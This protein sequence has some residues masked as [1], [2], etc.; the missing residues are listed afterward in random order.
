LSAFWRKANGNWLL[1]R[2]PAESQRQFIL[3]I[4]LAFERDGNKKPRQPTKEADRGF[5]LLSY[6]QRII[7]SEASCN[8]IFSLMNSPFHSRTAAWSKKKDYEFIYKYLQIVSP[9]FN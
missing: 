3:N 5:S 6:P 8:P 9:D 1:V 2:P 4:K 7:V